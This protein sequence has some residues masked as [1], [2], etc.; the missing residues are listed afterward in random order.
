MRAAITAAEEVGYQF[1]VRHQPAVELDEPDW[2][3]VAT[4]P[5]GRTL[6]PAAVESLE[7]R[8]WER[9]ADRV[10]SDR[11]QHGDLRA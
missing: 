10:A 4:T 8:A 7:R 2:V 3:V 11:Q 1:T 6:Y 9:A 5:D